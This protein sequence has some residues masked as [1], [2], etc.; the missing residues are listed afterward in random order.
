MITQALAQMILVSFSVVA[1]GLERRHSS[2]I[3]TLAGYLSATGTNAFDRVFRGNHSKS[4]AGTRRG[5]R[6]DKQNTQ[7]HP[8]L[9]IT[10]AFEVFSGTKEMVEASLASVAGDL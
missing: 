9:A 8:A 7:S 2:N 5:M 3:G 6:S 4:K 1:C 10:V